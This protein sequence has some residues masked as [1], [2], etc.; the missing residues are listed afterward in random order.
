MESRYCLCYDIWAASSEVLDVNGEDHEMEYCIDAEIA[1]RTM[2]F[3]A[4]VFEGN[5][6]NE[7]S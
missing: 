2:T 5:S 6:L 4:V 7:D 3:R 1:P